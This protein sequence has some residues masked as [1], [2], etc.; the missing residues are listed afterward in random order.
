MHIREIPDR[1]SELERYNRDYEAQHFRYAQTNGRIGS[2][3]RDL[4]LGFYLPRFLIPMGR[5]VVN[6]GVANFTKQ[7]AG[8][9]APH[10]VTVN[11]VHPGSTVT[12]RLHQSFVRQ[13]R[14]AGVDLAEIEARNTASIPDRKQPLSVASTARI[15]AP[16]SM[17][18]KGRG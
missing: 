9:A 18:R 12:E 1:M 5:P 17:F 10:N 15:P 11:C 2:L 14:D 4:L 7:F 8:H 16:E 13:A 6:A 3:T